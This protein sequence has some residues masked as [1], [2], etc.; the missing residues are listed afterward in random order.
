M[1]FSEAY[2]PVGVDFHGK[3]RSSA[4]TLNF[5]ADKYPSLFAG[6]SHGNQSA[7]G[8]IQYLRGDEPLNESIRDENISRIWQGG[9]W[10]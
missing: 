8:D 7:S 6:F 1:D 3:T 4:T 5:E 2:V 10:R 9:F